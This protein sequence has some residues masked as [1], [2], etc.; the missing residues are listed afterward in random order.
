MINIG[1]GSDTVTVGFD[2]NKREWGTRDKRAERDE[3]S[4]N[5]PSIF[6]DGKQVSYD[7]LVEETKEIEKEL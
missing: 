1:F 6:S 3:V 5:I 7:Q 2:A 4:S